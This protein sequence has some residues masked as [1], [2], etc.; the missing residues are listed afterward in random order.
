MPITL[1]DAR[2]GQQIAEQ[3]VCRLK[4]E[5]YQI[6]ADAEGAIRQEILRRYMEAMLAQELRRMARRQIRP[7]LGNL[8]RLCRKLRRIDGAAN[9]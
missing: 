8:R 4:S 3:A 9:D 5:G 6:P 2:R 1:P 7:S